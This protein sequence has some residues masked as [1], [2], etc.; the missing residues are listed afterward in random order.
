MRTSIIAALAAVVTLSAVGG[1]LRA[2]DATM[3]GAAALGDWTKDAP[4][5]TRKI[6][7]ADLPKPG[8][9]GPPG[10]NIWKLVARPPDSMP[11]ALPDFTVTPFATGL[12]RPRGMRT[13][14]NGDLFIG[15]LGT[16][17]PGGLN[18]AANPNTGRILVMRAGA[19]PGTPPDVF[20]EGLDRPFGIAFYPAGPNPRY[21]YIGT[22]TQIVRYPYHAGD[23]HASGPCVRITQSGV[24]RVQTRHG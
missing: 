3:T 11:H 14:P 15:D 17:Q 6:V 2:Q 19:A 24:D 7:P 21:V 8:A 16:Y 23:V 22:T 9:D 10:S 5:V 1:P 18:L 4:G 20:A 12:G 13:A